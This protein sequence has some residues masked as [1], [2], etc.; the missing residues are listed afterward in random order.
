MAIFGHFWPVEP[1]DEP[2]IEA[3]VRAATQLGCIAGC[4]IAYSEYSGYFDIDVTAM[5]DVALR[6]I[7]WI[8]QR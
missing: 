4:N 2:S 5:G 3:T 7:L 6:R 8:C 1:C